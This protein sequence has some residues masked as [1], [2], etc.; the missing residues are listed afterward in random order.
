MSRV[1]EIAHQTSVSSSELGSVLSKELLHCIQ[2]GNCS[3]ICPLGFAMEFPPSRMISAM[4][5]GIFSHVTRSDSVWLCIACSACTTA[6]P[7][8]IPITEELMRS[9]KE[10][11][12]LSGNIPPE[13]Q[14]AFENS[15]RYGNPMG[16]S[17]RKRADWTESLEFVIPVLGRESPDADVL[18]FVG[19][20]SSYHPAVRTATLAFA[21]I[22]DVLGVN[23]GILGNQESSDGDSQRLAGEKGL[24]E[25]LAEKNA[26]A[27]GKVNV[28]QVITTDP[29][30]FNAFKNAYPEIGITYP[31]K[32]YTQFLAEKMDL[33]KPHI[34]KEV[35]A[36]V[37]F[38][39]P[40]YLGRVN[41]IY[42]EPRDLIK[43][44]PGLEL[45]EM[46]HHHQNSLCCG[47]GGGGM[48][49][50][51]FQWEK[52][53]VR[54]SEWRIQEVVDAGADTL[55]VACPYEKPR[56]LDAVKNVPGAQN[57]KVL[58]LSELLLESFGK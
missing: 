32:H 2:C 12:I 1:D 6:C 43:A 13:L 19:D 11:L 35:K 45:V 46:Q 5:A 25:I 41:G 4:R 22:L 40:C 29:H 23:F 55:V 39:D 14:S 58:D 21:R 47:G 53:H 30:A 57:V 50:D 15:Q 42:D 31:V 48:W 37:T 34:K 26:R 52:S 8:L 33:L 18:W 51:G 38:H 17:P 20:Y 7:S 24:F 56:F 49:L 3:G 16:E 36:R 44:I 9:T 28:T 27:L 54:S 10:E